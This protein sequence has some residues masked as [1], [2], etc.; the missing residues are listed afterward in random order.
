MGSAF[1]KFFKRFNP[2][3]QDDPSGKIFVAA[4]GKHP[5]W[6]DH[7]DDIG[8]ETDVFVTVKRI[9]YIQGIGGNIDSGSWDKLKEDQLIDEFKHVFFWYINGKLVVG[10]MWSSQDGKGRKSYPFVVCVQYNNLPIKWIFENVLPRL[11]KLEATCA[12]T[13]S[14]NDVRMAIQNVEQELR[15]LAQQS[16]TA[17]SPVVVYPD[18]VARLARH[19]EMGPN[20][21]GL[22]R[23][24]Y[25]IEREVGRHRTN[26][27]STMAMRSTSL[28]I[29]TSGD[30]ILESILLWNSFLFNM[31][32]KNTPM[33]ILIP[34]RYNWADVII[35]DPTELQLYCLRASLKVIPLTS[36][37]PYNMGSEFIDQANKLIKDS[38]SD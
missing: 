22:L 8:F 30:T 1:K 13:T 31:F 26:S 36:S 28:R 9:L 15:Q 34:Q 27:A 3:G 6:D 2:K 4:F 10:R 18:A 12:A 14:A 19:P 29:P 11:E 20:Q 24:L 5:G 37:I 23:V 7:I 21:E 25:H 38:L 35:G 16:E 33:L 17:P 32:G